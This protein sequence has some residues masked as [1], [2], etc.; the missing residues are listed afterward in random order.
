MAPLRLA[1]GHLLSSSVRT[2]TPALGPH[3]HTRVVTDEPSQWRR[4]D[5]ALLQVSSPVCPLPSLG[6]GQGTT[7]LLGRAAASFLLSLSPA[8]L[9]LLPFPPG[10][11]M[12]LPAAPGGV[13][14]PCQE[15]AQ[16][17]EH[18]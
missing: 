6:K 10:P 14:W 1:Q 5:L 12:A 7:Q 18:I 15:Q 2:G 13:V 8:V 9:W 11:S 16:L 3:S 17:E 4:L